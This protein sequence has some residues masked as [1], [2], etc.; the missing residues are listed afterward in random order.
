MGF[1]SLF[2]LV[3]PN[4]FENIS[5]LSLFIESGFSKILDQHSDIYIG[6][7]SFFL[8]SSFSIFCL[9]VLIPPLDLGFLDMFSTKGVFLGFQSH[10]WNIISKPLVKHHLWLKHV[11]LLVWLFACGDMYW[12]EGLPWHMQTQS[13]HNY[14]LYLYLPSY[15]YF[16]TATCR[17]YIVQSPSGRKKR[18]LKY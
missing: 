3:F 1:V 16:I 10:L 15:I 14:F 13:L 5:I 18:S 2:G 12:N 11:W 6:S 7:W 17:C 9:F 8:F 4:L